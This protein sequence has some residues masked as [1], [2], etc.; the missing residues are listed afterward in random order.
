[1]IIEY[2][3]SKPNKETFQ[4]K[5]IKKLIR[6]YVGLAYLDVFPYPFDMDA[7]AMLKTFENNPIYN[8]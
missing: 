5:P 1:M 4:I 6:K 2:S 8:S 7:L 3:K